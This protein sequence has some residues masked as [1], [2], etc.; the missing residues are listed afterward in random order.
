MLW[1]SAEIIAI[2]I[3]RFL[4]DWQAQL[5]RWT[6]KRDWLAARHARPVRL[7]VVAADTRRNRAAIVPFAPT[8]TR[9]L[10][11]VTRAVMNAIRTGAPLGSDGLCWIRE[12]RS[13]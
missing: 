9:L 6:A 5:R 12:R 4:L 8:I 13:M 11:A 2:E 10:P 1:G 3:D 7:V